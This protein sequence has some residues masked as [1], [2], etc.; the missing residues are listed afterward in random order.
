MASRPDDNREVFADL[1]LACAAIVAVA[2][3]IGLPLL[4]AAI[5]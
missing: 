3:T 4:L 5:R 1:A 2:L